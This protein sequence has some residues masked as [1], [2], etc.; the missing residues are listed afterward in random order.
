MLCYAVLCCAVLSCAHAC[1]VRTHVLLRTHVLYRVY[2]HKDHDGDLFAF[3]SGVLYC[4][5]GLLGG[6]VC[7]WYFRGRYIRSCR[8]CRV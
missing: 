2:H 6:K 3:T 4:V 8:T 5:G 1:A 7:D